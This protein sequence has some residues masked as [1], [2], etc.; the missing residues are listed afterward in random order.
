MTENYDDVCSLCGNLIVGDV[1]TKERPVCSSCNSQKIDPAYFI[2][3]KC[4]KK[5]RDL[6]GDTVVTETK[7]LAVGQKEGEVKNE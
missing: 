4:M 7:L 6:L 1:A 2:C 5:I 3:D